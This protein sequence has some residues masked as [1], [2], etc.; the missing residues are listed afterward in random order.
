MKFDK[1]KAVFLA[2]LA[3]LTLEIAVR[4]W[5]WGQVPTW[6]SAVGVDLT[7]LVNCFVI[8]FWGL[9]PAVKGWQTRSR[10]N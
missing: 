10:K 1:V 9:R 5:F 6:P 2:L 7:L 4:R 3:W 8:G